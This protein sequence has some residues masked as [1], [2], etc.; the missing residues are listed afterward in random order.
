MNSTLL[1]KLSLLMLCFL[2]S[3]R[4][5]DGLLQPWT[6]SL[7]Q[8]LLTILPLAEGLSVIPTSDVPP[9]RVSITSAPKDSVGEN[10]K[11][12]DI[13]KGYHLAT[14]EEIRRITAEDWNQDVRHLK[15]KFEDDIQYVVVS[16]YNHRV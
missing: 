10:P 5:I 9:A 6:E 2:M 16:Q 3:R 14:V 7:L 15:L 12:F 13:D 4:S 8:Q 1:G 11:P